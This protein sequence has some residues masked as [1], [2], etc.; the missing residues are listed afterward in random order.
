MGL[1][2]AAAESCLARRPL[3]AIFLAQWWWTSSRLRPLG[4]HQSSASI[5]H[6]P[7]QPVFL[8]Q[9]VAADA[10]QQWAAARLALCKASPGRLS[11][12]CMC[13]SSEPEPPFQTAARSCIGKQHGHN[14]MGQHHLYRLL[15]SLAGSGGT[16]ASEPGSS[17]A[18]DLLSAVREAQEAALGPDPDA[19]ARQAAGELKM[20]WGNFWEAS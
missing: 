6:Q 3:S 2:Q 12:H 1:A 11:E 14:C 20:W 10:P 8:A 15:L 5:S 19:Q 13:P 17:L 18:G 9:R 7:A 16:G 4:Q